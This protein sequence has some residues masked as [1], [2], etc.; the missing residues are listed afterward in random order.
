MLHPG[1]FPGSYCHA[2][3]EAMKIRIALLLPA[4]LIII[5]VIGLACSAG[6]SNPLLPGQVE[7]EPRPQLSRSPAD[8]FVGGLWEVA[9]DTETS[10][11]NILQQRSAEKAM[12]VLSF[13][14]PPVLF[15]L[16]INLSTLVVDP[17]TGYVG[18]NVTLNHPLYSASGQYD[19]FD[20]RGIVFGPKLTNADG[21]TPLLR[22]SD[23][24]EMPFGYI[25]GMIGTPHIWGGY[26]ESEYPYKYFADGLNAFQDLTDFFSDPTA[27]VQRGIFSEGATNVRHYD[28]QFD[29]EG[30]RFLVFN[31]AVLTSYDFPA[32]APP[33]ELGDFPIETANCAEPFHI[34]CEVLHNG[35]YFDSETG[36]GGTVSLNVE[37][38]DWQNL[39]NVE[40]KIASP[41][42]IPS[43]T[44]ST[45][46]SGLTLKSGLF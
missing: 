37:A 24:S 2:E 36:G 28:L 25:D 35:L 38:Y 21:Y 15:F 33:F 22:P 40:V 20:V 31:Y 46:S 12:N 4:I 5:V 32:G 42:V 44:R 9:I 13:L 19:G 43:T 45:C 16:S 23:F 29:V 41:G 3:D 7:E 11:A 1:R 34:D 17:E 8:M 18:A 39:Q 6:K 27:L 30:G 26:D 10:T 14:E